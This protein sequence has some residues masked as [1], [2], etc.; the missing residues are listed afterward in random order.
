M[1]PKLLLVWDLFSKRL[2]YDMNGSSTV[3]KYMYDDNYNTVENGYCEC[4]YHRNRHKNSHKAI[5][6]SRPKIDGKSS[7]N[8][9][10]LSQVDG[11]NVLNIYSS[12]S[13]YLI[14]TV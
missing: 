11:H 7:H 14:P 5:E 1:R 9:R 4:D 12:K 8:I 13:Q 3:H 2:H 10:Y 6:L